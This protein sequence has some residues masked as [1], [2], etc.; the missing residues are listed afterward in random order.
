MQTALDIDELRR[1]LLAAKRATYAAQGD[2]A[3][4]TPLLP[5]SKQLE[6]SAAPFAYRDIYFGL[7]RFSG[8]ELVYEAER[9]LWSMTYSGGLLPEATQENAAEI[10]AFLRQAL[11]ALPADLPL[12]GPAALTDGALHYRCE[13]TG[14]LAAFRGQES[15]SKNDQRLY[16]LNFAGG[17]LN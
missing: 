5:Q 10:Y 2:A 14:T 9:P 13:I 7:F 15:I 16:E 8:Q 12:R 3:S 1:F 4:V 6:Y 11:L 17:L